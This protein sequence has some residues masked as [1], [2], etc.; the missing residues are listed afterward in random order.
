MLDKLTPHKKKEKTENMVYMYFKSFG[1]NFFFFFF[2]FMWYYKQWISQFLGDLEKFYCK[3]TVWK[4]YTKF[5]LK[6]VQIKSSTTKKTNQ[7]K[8]VKNTF[9]QE[10]SSFVCFFILVA[11]HLEMTF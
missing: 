9:L 5:F 11:F 6:P 8:C 4:N 7:K 10:W 2:I 3:A 1:F